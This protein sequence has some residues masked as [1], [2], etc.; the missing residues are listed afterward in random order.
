MLWSLLGK[1]FTVVARIFNVQSILAAQLVLFHATF[2]QQG[3]FRQ[4]AAVSERAMGVWVPARPQGRAVG[5][6]PMRHWPRHG[7]A[8]IA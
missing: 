8:P 4:G 3:G 2:N 5:G 7:G 1:I 6:R